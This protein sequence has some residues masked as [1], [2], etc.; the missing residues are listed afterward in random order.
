MSI[1]KPQ[2]FLEKALDCRDPEIW[3]MRAPSS[4][5]DEKGGKK[6]PASTP[7]LST[8]AAT[9]I[10]G[11]WNALNQQSRADRRGCFCGIQNVEASDQIDRRATPSGLATRHRGR[12]TTGHRVLLLWYTTEITTAGCFSLLNCDVRL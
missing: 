11:V 12:E 8:Q 5:T 2:L 9:M 7:S 6:A 1:G 3:T 4:T 10:S